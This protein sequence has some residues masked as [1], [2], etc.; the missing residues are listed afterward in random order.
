MFIKKIVLFS[1]L[2]VSVNSYAQSQGT[3]EQYEILF[4]SMGVN[5]TIDFKNRIYTRKLG[6][7]TCQRQI[8][9]NISYRCYQNENISYRCYQ[10][11]NPSDMLLTNHDY[12]LESDD[13]NKLINVQNHLNSNEIL[14]IG[15]FKF[16]NLG[17]K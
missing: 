10:N 8:H 11:D 3:D 13:F 7:I 5:F 17:L 14:S 2:A 15:D 16:H 6:N 4:Y 12:Y 9:E 1:A